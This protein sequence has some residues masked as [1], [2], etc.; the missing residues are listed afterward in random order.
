MAHHPAHTTFNCIVEI[1]LSGKDMP[2]FFYK[3]IE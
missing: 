1:E 3:Q 2:G